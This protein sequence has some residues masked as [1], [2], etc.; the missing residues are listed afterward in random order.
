M[1]GYFIIIS[2]LLCVCEMM[3]GIYINIERERKK[4]VTRYMHAYEYIIYYIGY[5]V[6]Y[7]N[8]D[9]FIIISNND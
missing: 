7:L 6:F 1:D 3:W 4:Y 8:Y 2:H 5:I 9:Y